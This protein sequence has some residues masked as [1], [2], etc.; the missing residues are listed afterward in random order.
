ME[1]KAAVQSPRSVRQ[2]IARRPHLLNRDSVD[3]NDG[4]PPF[5]TIPNLPRFNRVVR[6]QAGHDDDSAL[7]LKT[8]S[9]RH[10]IKL[11]L[12]LENPIANKGIYTEMKQRT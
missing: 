11:A 10:V 5:G 4:A 3:G 9:T 1:R 7:I 2:F 8:E 12:Y 6:A